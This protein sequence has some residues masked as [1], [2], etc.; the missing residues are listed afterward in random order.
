M[1]LQ[2]PAD[3]RPGA[4]ARLPPSLR[5]H[6][7]PRIGSDLSRVR[8]HTGADAEASADRLDAR[9]YTVDQDIYFAA[10]EYQPDTREGRRLIA[11]ELAHAV[12]G[13]TE[14][15]AIRRQ[16]RGGTPTPPRL[17]DLRVDQQGSIQ[18]GNAVMAAVPD[19][20]FGSPLPPPHGVQITGRAAAGHGGGELFFT[21]MI[22]ASIR[23]QRRGTAFAFETVVDEFDG[24]KAFK[25]RATPISG[26]GTTVI[27]DTDTPGGS[28]PSANLPDIRATLRF[29]DLFRVFLMWRPSATAPESTW[30][31]LTSGFWSWF[32]AAT[33][34]SDRVPLLWLLPAEPF[35]L[36][37]SPGVT[38][39][40]KTTPDA[41]PPDFSRPVHASGRAPITFVPGVFPD[42]LGA[43]SFEQ[44]S[45]GEQKAQ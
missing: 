22:A 7:E 25:G 1:A 27:N 40:N 31:A 29:V 19:L 5:A 43:G 4:D 21:Q 33:G 9:A 11:H 41:T 34:V 39:F 38:T 12:Q 10:G 42:P 8:L 32:A 37:C 30:V 23:L 28:M 14:A 36:I 18:A 35:H 15:P 2:T 20:H 45:Q 13:S 17:I 16:P 44:C 6:F 3:G 24:N 26:P